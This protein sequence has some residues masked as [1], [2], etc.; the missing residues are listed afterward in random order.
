MQN[1]F[2]CE[3]CDF[4]PGGIVIF[5]IDSDMKLE[6]GNKYYYE[7]FSNGKKRNLNICEEDKLIIENAIRNLNENETT[8]VYYSCNTGKNGKRRL[9][10]SV[11]KDGE[12]RVF[13]VMCD[14]TSRYNV[15]INV[16][17]E[18]EKFA[19]ALCNSQNIV[20]DDNLLTHKSTLYIP[21]K[22]GSRIDT[23]SM[24]DSEGY[25]NKENIHPNDREQF[26]EKVY[27]PNEAM[28]SARMKLPDDKSWKWYRVRRQFELDCDGKPMRIFGVISNIDEEKLH[29]KELREKIEIDPVLKIYNRNAAVSRIDEYL[30]N[31]AGNRDFALIVL[32]IDDFKSINDT[33]GHLYG[34]AVISMVTEKMRSVAEPYGILG[35][36]GGDEFFVFLKDMNDGELSEIIEKI[37]QSINNVLVM[38]EK[39]ITCSIGAAFG[40]SFDFNPKYKDLFE[41]A[42]KALYNVKRNGKANWEA[43][44]EKIMG[45]SGGH[46]IDYESEDD[47]SNI[48]LLESRDMM[49]V[50]LEL[51]AGAKTS[52]AAIYKI[53]HYVAE[54]FDIDWLQ[55]MQVNCREDLITIKYEWCNDSSFRNNSGRSGYYVHSDIERFRDYFEKN[56]VFIIKPGNTEGFSMKFQREFEK[57]MRHSVLY[58][59]NI[60]QDDSFYMF[61]CTRFGKEKEWKEKES[62]EL[63][64]ATKMMTMYVA[65]ADKETENEV[66]YKKMVD[67]DKKTGLYNI[68]KFY[69]QIGRLRKIALENDESVA[70]IH[71]DIDNF[72]KFNREFGIEAGD[73]VIASFAKYINGNDN[74]SISISA[75]LDGTDIFLSALRIKTGELDFIKE[76]EE[77]NK[78][79]CEIQNKKYPGSNI[80][81]K[82]GVYILKKNDIGGE[83]LD[84]ALMAKRAVKD[85][86]ESFCVLY[87]EK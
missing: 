63:N 9:A 24:P 85:F 72:L 43:Y 68:Q 53:I 48:E 25:L 58:N 33:Y 82:T 70:V 83:G 59:A 60:T 45:S 64:S 1:D 51:S 37:M 7:Y 49:K 19:S 29:E 73:D 75:H 52:D 86:K 12:N 74:P 76:V 28:L 56:P 6:Y 4:I 50:F 14:I 20:F 69:E 16:Q 11:R 41:R 21:Q 32:D 42:D 8:T 62:D 71:T 15:L 18:K 10:M 40:S 47:K 81:M 44:D 80:I 17:K 27:N 34:D 55:I 46:A 39:K 38:E 26:L 23:I 5:L 67:Y 78:S 57:N 54:K 31:N 36:Y 13:G 61:V 22:D 79:F 66:R 35:R 84:L 65:Q 77:V 2:S 87:E 3:K 30:E